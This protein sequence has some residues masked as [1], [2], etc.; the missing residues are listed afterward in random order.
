MSGWRFARSTFLAFLLLAAFA[1][2]ASA[3]ILGPVSTA[4]PT[5]TESP[6]GVGGYA[7]CDGGSDVWTG[8]D[9]GT[10]FVSGWQWY[11]NGGVI[12]GETGATYVVAHADVNTTLTCADQVSWNHGPADQGTTALGLQGPGL[13][14]PPSQLAVNTFPPAIDPSYPYAG[15]ALTCFSNSWDG[16]PS[17]YHYQWTVANEPVGVDSSDYTAA[18]ADVG[19]LV[20]CSVVADNDAGASAPVAS[21]P[22]TVLAA[23]P[24]AVVTRPSITPTDAH[25]GDLADCGTGTWS[26]PNAALSYAWKSGATS[27]GTDSQ[28]Y[29]IDHTDI[30][31]PLTC[32]ITATT[33][34]PPAATATS[35]A[36]TPTPPPPPTV[37]TAPSIFPASAF[38]GDDL[39]CD[40]GSWSDFAATFSYR[41]TSGAASVGTDS[42]TYTTVLGDAGNVVVC[43]VTA[44]TPLGGPSAPADSNAVVPALPAPASNDLLPSIAPDPAYA[45]DLLSCDP[46]SW[47]GDGLTY[48]YRWRAGAADLGTGPT[49]QT[50]DGDA[51]TTITCTVTASNI[52]GQVA[53][54][55]AGVLVAPLAA[56]ANTT[57][58]R[59]NPAVEAGGSVWCEPGTWTGGS[60]TL[61]Y[62]W[63]R[64]DRALA[65]TSDTYTTTPGDTGH[66]VTCTVT[67]DNPLHLPASRDSNAIAIVAAGAPYPSLPPFLSLAYLAPTDVETCD[68]GYW[69][70]GPVTFT[71]AWL[72]NGAPAG[73]GPTYRVRDAD[74]GAAITCRVAGTALAGGD[75]LAVD[76]ASITVTAIATPTPVTVPR[77]TTGHRITTVGDLA[78]CLSDPWR[79]G[80]PVL[81][82]RWQ[83]DG[84]DVPNDVSW[85]VPVLPADAGHV[86]RCVVTAT[87]AAGHAE[88]T[89]DPTSTILAMTAPAPPGIPAVSAPRTLEGDIAVCHPPT[90]N[91]FPVRTTYSWALN[92]SPI[93][94]EVG[95]NHRISAA[96]AGGTLTC[97][98]QATNALGTS[99]AA[100]ST[101][102]PLAALAAPTGGVVS[103]TVSDRA[104]AGAQLVCT[105][106]FG[107]APTAYSYV[108]KKD[109]TPIDGATR[110]SLET[111]AADAGGAF[112]CEVTATNATGSSAAI[113]SPPVTLVALAVPTTSG[114]PGLDTNAPE[115]TGTATCYTPVYVGLVQALG[116]RWLIDGVPV[117]NERQ[118]S[119][120]IAAG[121][122]GKALTCELTAYNGA[123]PAA[124]VVSP[125][126]SI[127]ALVVPVAS[128]TPAVYGTP[129]PTQQLQCVGPAW[130]GVVDS[131]TD[132]WQRDDVAI[133]GATDWHYTLVA[134]DLGHTVRCV[135]TAHNGAGASLPASSGFVYVVPLTAPEP[136]TEPSGGYAD[137][138]EVGETVRCGDAQF[139]PAAA[140]TTNVILRDDGTELST[141]GS[142]TPVTADIGHLLVCRSTGQN[143]VGHGIALGGWPWVIAPMVPTPHGLPFTIGAADITWHVGESVTCA[144]PGFLG[145]AATVAEGWSTGG[146]APV[147]G[148]SHVVAAAD[149]GQPTRCVVSATTHVGAHTGTIAGAPLVTAAATTPYGGTPYLSVDLA[150]VGDQIACA[151]GPWRATPT[152]F[153]RTWA[154][155]GAPIAGQAGEAYT[156][157]A[158]DANAGVACSVEASNALGAGT[159]STTRPIWVLPQEAP[160]QRSE[161]TT[162]TFEAGPYPGTL[163][164]CRPGAWGGGG[165]AFTYAWKRDA[166]PIP[167]QTAPTYAATTADVGKTIACTVTATN[168]RGSITVPTTGIVFTVAPP[169]TVRPAALAPPSIAGTPVVGSLLTCDRGTW[170]YAP[171]AYAIAWKRGT[172]TI[173]NAAAATYTVTAADGGRAITCVVTATNNVGSTTVA[174][175]AATVPAVVPVNA[176]LPKVAGAAKVGGTLTCSPGTWIGGASF[177]YRYQWYRGTVRIAKAAAARYR[178]TKA[179]R[180]KKVSCRVVAVDSAGASRASASKAVVVK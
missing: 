135:E 90:S 66:R 123:G 88:S 137:P 30:G 110:R 91:V 170:A 56:P 9:S 140:S 2:G 120:R 156:A 69:S 50:G 152:S 37:V 92:G 143:A 33:R 109:G 17:A 153:A 157:A 145:D 52:T 146:G 101:G 7:Y 84:V 34:F 24:P 165:V 108:W 44:S 117:A 97:T 71:I 114:V 63:R 45:R 112:T 77:I 59:L 163:V 41:W 70:N 51:A 74:I 147:D 13:A 132:A 1:A 3:G 4:G 43:H 161:A 171:S 36:V 129:M 168:P 138:T 96:E 72:R 174:S 176:A 99:A 180:K 29:T 144:L 48:T 62:A 141:T 18:P 10:D 42:A 119:Y 75:P 85:Q 166:T 80:T 115:P 106:S 39:T 151:E 67:A 73:S 167:G 103:I 149:L 136:S 113:A 107:G 76:S 19:K 162:A 124:P 11:R 95:T 20:V 58:P 15:D 102:V 12:A 22:V 142:Y 131:V 130:E 164:H 126:V 100:T 27:V 94:G 47:S 87:N 121:D 31:K 148:A 177:T 158:G 54:T 122:V 155:G 21:N 14:I 35:D 64:D 150:W 6:V 25:E 32:T 46:G 154:R 65:E 26:D 23:M 118:D 111:A 60:I 173:A 134:A 82:Y 57:P 86:L 104:V 178:P 133:P 175:A 5:A 81:T 160:L 179:D 93:P 89:S 38:V 125:P 127:R 8:Y 40:A 53:A 172:A 49:Y 78:Q 28:Y 128:T 159:T 105:A 139:Q 68:P 83:R 61:A 55:S 16:Y 98:T 116:V 79:G 169:Q